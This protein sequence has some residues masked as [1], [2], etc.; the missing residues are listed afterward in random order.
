[1]ADV[2]VAE[3]Q[4]P[5]KRRR[6]LPIWVSVW[7][8]VIK[9]KRLATVGL[10]I[11]AVFFFSGIFANFVAPESYKE[12]H[13]E[14]LELVD[15]D[16]GYQAIQYVGPSWGHPFGLDERG[17]DV[18]SLVIYGA[19]ISL[20]VGLGTILVGITFAT[21]VGLGS[22]FL[23]GKI[24]TS[25]QRIVDGVMVFPWLVALLVIV[26]TL[27]QRSPVDWI[28][29]SWWGVLKVIFTLGILDIAWVSRIIR[30]AALSAKE[31][32]YVDAAK[33]LGA[34]GTRIMFR[35]MLPNIMAPIITMA[36]LTMG[37]AIL[38]EAVLSFLG[39]GVPP[40]N[41]SWGNML[42]FQGR[43]YLFRAPWMAIV[44]G[45]IISMVVFAINVLGDGLR[46]ILDPRM[47]G[48]GAAI[49]LDR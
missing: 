49:G 3:P 42:S 16:A 33:A 17:R 18:L 40:P 32:Q 9:E 5:Y 6:N 31:N 39:Y 26:T 19:R 21:I 41:P 47:R 43:D 24:D 25:I 35:H 28:D 8:R 2:A 10:V 29:T 12:Q 30:S 44:P 15:T 38:S 20:I 45:V 36:T 13:M 27:P 23:G 11:L 48:A 34:P 14:R 22:A 46:D 7:G 37:F 1:M 4:W